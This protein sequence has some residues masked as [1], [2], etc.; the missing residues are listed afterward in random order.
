MAR[1]RGETVDVLARA[2]SPQSL[3]ITIYGAYSR[4]LGG[5]M[6]VAALLEL[7]RSLEI[8]DAASR[9]AL[10]RLKRK[11]VLLSERVD[12]T[13]GYRIGESTRRIFDIGDARVLHRRAPHTGSDWVL[14]TFSIPESSRD[15]RYRLRSRLARI[16]FGQVSPGLWIGPA[17]LETDVRY[18]VERLEISE[19]VQLFSGEYLGFGS[20]A[21]A[22]GRWWDLDAIAA[23]YEEFLDAYGP[24][25]R[26][27]KREKDVDPESAFIDYTRILT[28]WRPIPYLDPGLPDTYLPK[29]WPG[30]KASELFFGLH[31]QLAK[32]AAQHVRYIARN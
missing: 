9:S 32:A 11:D 23:M 25:G 12:G 14:A 7:L 10:S 18:V 24:L 17:H 19:F 22:I 21:D 1:V 28:S 29:N 16:G 8:E 5:A 26:A 3:I 2:E 4:P 27:W 30:H 20:T 31:D 6:A 15:L 13:P